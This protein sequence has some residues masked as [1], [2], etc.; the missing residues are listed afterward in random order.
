GLILA[1]RDLETLMVQASGLAAEGAELKEIKQEF[2]RA[3]CAV[4]R[5]RDFTNV[6][7]I[8]KA[9]VAALVARDAEE[10]EKQVLV[11]F[12]HLIRTY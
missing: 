8:R 5:L 1:E 10:A 12:D 6:A 7:D 3:W 9:L 11:F 4:N 2:R